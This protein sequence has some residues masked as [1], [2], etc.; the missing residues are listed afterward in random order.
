MSR[1]TNYNKS[2]IFQSG[3]K[4]MS[5][6][7]LSIITVCYNARDALKKTLR[8]VLL[9]SFPSFEYLVIDGGSTDGTLSLLK[10]SSGLFARAQIPFRYISESDHGIY[11]A[12]NKGTQTAEGTWLLFL[13]AGDLLADPHILDQ[14]FSMSSS[15]SVIYGDTVCVYQNRQ[16]LY[17]ALP[18]SDVIH[19]MAFCHQ[20]AFI[21]RTLLL[22]HPYDTSYHICA[23]HHFFL[24]MYLKGIHFD[25]RPVP[26]SIY[27]IAGYSDNNKL[28]AHREQNRMQRELHVFRP[29]VAWFLRNCIFYIKLL[30][31]LIGGRKIIDL[32][33]QKRLQ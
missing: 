12:M 7:T 5:A 3:R 22:E 23:D 6:P 25:Y 17:P 32:V 9:Q 8:N 4:T 18:L 15:G 19:K 20:S 24:S 13:N 27:E 16:K 2:S 10:Q 21:R 1:P 31:K 26:V 28:A 29:T 30:I 14:I 11:D 33:R